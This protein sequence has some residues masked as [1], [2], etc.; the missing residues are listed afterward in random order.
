MI[1]LPAYRSPERK[2]LFLRGNEGRR[3]ERT[4]DDLTGHLVCVTPVR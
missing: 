3:G 2:E 1:S 4:G